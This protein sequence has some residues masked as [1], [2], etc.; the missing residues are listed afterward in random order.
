MNRFTINKKELKRLA[1]ETAAIIGVCALVFVGI[2]QTAYSAITNQTDMVAAAGNSQDLSGNSSSSI[3]AGYVKADYALQVGQYS[4]QPTAQDISREDA[5]ERGAQ[6]L[7]RVFGLDLSGKTIEMTYHPVTSTQPRATWTGIVTISANQS[8]YFD[9]DA[10]TGEVRSTHLDKYWNEGVD[11]GMDA[12][13]MQNH[14]QYD[15]LAKAIA[16]K[17][18]LVAGR[19]ASVEYYGQGFTTNP[20]GAKNADVQMRVTSESGQQAQ[21]E[22]SRYNQEFLGVDYDCWVKEVTL[23][24]KQMEN[25]L[26][27]RDTDATQIIIDDIGLNGATQ[28]IVDDIGLNGATKQVTIDNQKIECPGSWLKVFQ[29]AK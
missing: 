29:R 25:N 7:W 2:T 11:T 20:S 18:Q 22:F 10:V 16:E 14:A 17:Y 13:L 27:N 3:P 8:Y 23:I 12:S 28:I 15:S 1:L 26:R 5:A 4:S 9:I 6:D 19:V 24:E 21:L